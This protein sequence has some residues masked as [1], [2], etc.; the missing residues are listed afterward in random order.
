MEIVNS[1]PESRTERLVDR[2]KLKEAEQ[3][4]QHESSLGCSGLAPA[5]LVREGGRSKGRCIWHQSIMDIMERSRY[6]FLKSK[7]LLTRE[8]RKAG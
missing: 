4:L 5:G 2:Q 1:L 8:P 3:E 7:E 6:Q